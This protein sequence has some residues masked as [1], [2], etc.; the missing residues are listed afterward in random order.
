MFVLDLLIITLYPLL[1]CNHLEEE[2]L[3]LLSF[4]CLFT[5]KIILFFLTVPWVGLQC[6]TV[7]F[8]D[9]THFFLHYFA[10]TVTRIKCKK[11]T[12]VRCMFSNRTVIFGIC[13]QK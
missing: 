10:V 7:T 4:R 1:F 9:H 6:V 3:L 2:S 12:I 8:P 5:L 11:S 13:I